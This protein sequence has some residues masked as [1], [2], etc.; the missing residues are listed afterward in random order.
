MIAATA[1]R[2]GVD[3]FLL[4]ALIFTE[5]SYNE[6]ARSYAGAKGLMQLMPL[7]V[8]H[9]GVDD[10]YDPAQNVDAGT[11][12]LRSLLDKYPRH[13]ALAAYHAGETAV[14]RHGGVPPFKST[15]RYIEKVTNHRR[16][17]CKN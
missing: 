1:A 4:H 11:R 7:M 14:R 3:L 8:R 2:H 15:R 9:L 10:P 6:R 5:S 17:L 12:L 13:I 16:T